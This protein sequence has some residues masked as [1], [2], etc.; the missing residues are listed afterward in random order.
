MVL[1]RLNPFAYSKFYHRS[2]GELMGFAIDGDEK[3]FQFWEIEFYTSS[4]VERP[5]LVVQTCVF[6]QVDSE[7]AK[8]GDIAVMELQQKAEA[9]TEGVVMAIFVHG[10]V[11]KESPL[12]LF[13]AL[14]IGTV[15]V[16]KVKI[17]ASGDMR[18]V[19]VVDVA[20]SG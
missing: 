4:L 18:K 5:F 16:V 2:M 15:S 3:T 8:C 10:F 14:E 13:H 20:A 6:V 19:A 9:A 12:K 11:A 7:I 1:N 17:E